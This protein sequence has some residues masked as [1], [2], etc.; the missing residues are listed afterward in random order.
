[1][2]TSRSTHQ[3]RGYAPVV[4]PR[5]AYRV[6][7]VFTPLALAFAVLLL[8]DGSWLSAVPMMIM[9]GVFGFNIVHLRRQGMHWNGPRSWSEWRAMQHERERG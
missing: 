9:V 4:R 1:M 8:V 7:L 2:S 6:S 3:S 5:N